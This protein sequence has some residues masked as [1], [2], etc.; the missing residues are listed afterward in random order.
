MLLCN[1]MN[2]PKAETALVRRGMVAF[3]PYTR[4]I[5]GK[6][7]VATAVWHIREQREKE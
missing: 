1:H 2:L 4:I 6:R 7:L 5:A 3:F